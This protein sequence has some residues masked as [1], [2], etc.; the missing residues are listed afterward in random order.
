MRASSF[1]SLQLF[2]C[3]P[4]FLLFLNF[5]CLYSVHPCAQFHHP[6]RL[7]VAAH[8]ELCCERA[9]L[10][11]GQSVLELGCGWGS[12]CLYMAARYPTSKITA[13]S[14]SRTQREH[15]EGVAR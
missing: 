2:S 13:V 5:F 7:P 9:Q 1:L 14:N 8:A 4:I 10:A 15:I 11:G 12:L 6:M 3:F